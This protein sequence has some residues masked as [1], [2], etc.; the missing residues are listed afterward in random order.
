MYLPDDIKK[1]PWFHPANGKKT[2]VF[3]SKL[4]EE[5]WICSCS[6]RG[7]ASLKVWV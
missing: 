4:G 2:D 3:S 7:R 6:C 1:F 5:P